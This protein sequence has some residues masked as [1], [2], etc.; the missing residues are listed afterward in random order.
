MKKNSNRPVEEKILY[1]TSHNPDLKV[2]IDVDPIMLEDVQLEAQLRA[3]YYK[4]VDEKNKSLERQAKA[5]MDKYGP[6]LERLFK[7]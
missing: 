2:E 5:M 3:D 6:V 4:R 7:T 1:T